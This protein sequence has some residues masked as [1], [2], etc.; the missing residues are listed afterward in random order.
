MNFQ[1]T[2]LTFLI[3][4]TIGFG[5]GLA[6]AWLHAPSSR[7]DA[8]DP[9][10]ACE[11][12]AVEKLQFSDAAS[13]VIEVPSIITN[14]AGE[15]APWVRLEVSIV[16]P[17]DFADKERHAAQLAQDFLGF[18]RTLQATQLTGGTNLQLLKEDLKE[19]ASIRT[20]RASLDVLIRTLI[21]E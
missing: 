15:N 5:A 7:A 14:L 19:I 18:V 16:L 4:T 8:S 10:P 2:A 9:K 20:S 6:A 3:V 17:R 1:Q 13:S 12:G 21:I 11:P